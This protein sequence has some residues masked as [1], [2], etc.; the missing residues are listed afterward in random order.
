MEKILKREEAKTEDT[1]ALEDLYPSV[2]TFR[3]DAARLE[4]LYRA[5]EGYKGKLGEGGALFLKMLDDYCEMN[6]LF[7]RLY[8][9]ANQ[10]LHEDL[11][12]SESQQLAG[13]TQVMMNI[14]NGASA[15][16]VPEILSLPAE[17][18]EEYFQEEAGLSKY[19]CFLDDIIE[20]II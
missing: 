6:Q 20:L 10:K 7:E 2:E 17:K 18:L 5:F 8:V 3:A 4:E 1:W 19:R 12:N 16:M 15:F 9:Y 11:G 13:E 14:L